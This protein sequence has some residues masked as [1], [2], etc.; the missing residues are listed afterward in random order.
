M[1]EKG[2]RATLFLILLRS[3][4]SKQTRF[5]IRRTRPRIWASHGDVREKCAG[6][7]LALLLSAERGV[8]LTGD[9]LEGRTEEPDRRA[10]RQT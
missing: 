1:Y 10:G 4:N 3:D 9:T 8:H 5:R 2:R 6:Q 7:C